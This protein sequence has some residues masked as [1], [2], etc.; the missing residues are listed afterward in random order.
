MLVVELTVVGLIVGCSGAL[1]AAPAAAAVV[2]VLVQGE[3]TQAESAAPPTLLPNSQSTMTETHTK[4]L[5]FTQ[6]KNDLF[7]KNLDYD[8][9][10]A[11]SWK[12]KA[13]QSD[14]GQ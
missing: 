12:I 7:K 13:I 8:L 11:M 10:A 4:R 3:Q 2:V 14:S 1:V 5:T 9:V 6:Q